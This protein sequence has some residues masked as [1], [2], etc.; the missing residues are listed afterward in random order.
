M[1]NLAI[2]KEVKYTELPSKARYREI[3]QLMLDFIKDAERY[4]ESDGNNQSAVRRA[5]DTLDSIGKAKMPWRRA[6]MGDKQ[7]G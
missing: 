2:E 6:T 4:Y 1:S 7:N 5:R 3:L